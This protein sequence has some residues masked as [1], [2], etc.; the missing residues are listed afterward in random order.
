VGK[1][2]PDETSDFDSD[3]EQEAAPAAAP[4]VPWP[5][6]LVCAI[7]LPSVGA[8]REVNVQMTARDLTVTVRRAHRHGRTLALHSN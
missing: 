6:R 2:R 7:K 8:A 4:E 3:E 5:L 1:Q